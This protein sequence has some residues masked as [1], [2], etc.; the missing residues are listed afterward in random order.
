MERYRDILLSLEERWLRK[1]KEV[2]AVIQLQ[3]VIMNIDLLN[4]IKAGGLVVVLVDEE[5]D[6]LKEM[7]KGSEAVV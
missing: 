5:L 4:E 1:K 3:E 7:E 2:P 6:R